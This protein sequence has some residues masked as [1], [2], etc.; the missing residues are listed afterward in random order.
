MLARSGRTLCEDE[1]KTLLRLHGIEAS[2]ERLATDAE[3]AVAAAQELG[4]PVALKIQSPDILHKTEI[5]GL[6]L[7]LAEADAVRQGFATLMERAKER[8][9]DA[10]L[11]GVLV[12]RMAPRGVEVIIGAVRDA[13]FGPL[14]MVGLGG[15]AVELFKD[16]AYRPAP[17]SREEARRMLDELRSAPLLRGFRGGPPLDV[18][19]LAGLVAE[20]SQIVASL[21]DEIA[22]FEL[23][24]VILHANGHGLTIAD[25]L[26]MRRD[27]EDAAVSQV[28]AP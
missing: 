3:A 11:R 14:M 5:G 24:P 28:A 13:T 26:L 27:L 25:A 21:A 4:F 2:A 9:P 10:K 7:N 20:I 12:Q 22:E 18:D 1:V 6:L 15:I 17:V 16:V 8:A 19:A 23:N